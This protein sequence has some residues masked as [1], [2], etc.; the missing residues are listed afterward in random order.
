[1]PVKR[2]LDEGF[3][4]GDETKRVTEEMYKSWVDLYGK[5][6]ADN[7]ASMTQEDWDNVEFPPEVQKVLDE[8]DDEE[9]D[10]LIGDESLLNEIDWLKD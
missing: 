4:V 10:L 3:V 9:G 1:M 5:E 6:E 8:L 7:L 2:N